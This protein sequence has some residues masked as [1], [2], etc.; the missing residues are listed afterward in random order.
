MS[1]EGARALGDNTE[2]ASR[3]SS[4]SDAFLN[5]A[6][7]LLTLG[8]LVTL[9]APVSSGAPLYVRPAQSK[10]RVRARHLFE[11][12]QV[13]GML[14][15]IV[16]EVDTGTDAVL[17]DVTLRIALNLNDYECCPQSALWDERG[18]RFVVGSGAVSC[19]GGGSSE[20]KVTVE[21]PN[22]TFLVNFPHL[23]QHQRLVLGVRCAAPGSGKVTVGLAGGAVLAVA[24]LSP[25]SPFSA[26]VGSSGGSV[27]V[28]FSSGFDLSVVSFSSKDLEC[29]YIRPCRMDLEN[30]YTAPRDL[31]QLVSVLGEPPEA[32]LYLVS[33]SRS[34]DRET[35]EPPKVHLDESAYR[36]HLFNDKRTAVLGF[37]S[38]RCDDIL[39]QE[40]FCSEAFG[41]GLCM[42]E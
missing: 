3:F 33:K 40:K 31:E 8:G 4:D 7:V 18:R 25:V 2:D 32:G 12:V 30:K 17:D 9:Q 1:E 42:F 14:M 21:R 22:R 27:L 38:K 34:D 39:S 37:R 20:W 41:L 6:L 29:K 36:L 10:V 19:A 11:G 26:T 35:N 23:K 15:P 28:R 5:P 13:C 16:F 24:R